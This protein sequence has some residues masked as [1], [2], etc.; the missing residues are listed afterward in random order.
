MYSNV[1]IVFTPRSDSFVNFIRSDLSGVG[2]AFSKT[3]FNGFVI[4]LT[5]QLNNLN[6]AHKSETIDFLD[7]L[8]MCILFEANGVSARL[9]E[10]YTH[11]H[12]RDMS[13][14]CIEDNGH[15]VSYDT[16]FH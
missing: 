16:N 6:I 10:L 8:E 2:T 13:C 5:T 4:G 7:A 11:F 15:V 12:S 14:T 9:L 1:K 3:R